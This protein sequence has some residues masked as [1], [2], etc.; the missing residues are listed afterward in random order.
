MARVT[1]TIDS[2][3]LV[4][5]ICTA[6]NSK[7][8]PAEEFGYRPICEYPFTRSGIPSATVQSP[9]GQCFVA[10]KRVR[11]ASLAIFL[12]AGHTHSFVV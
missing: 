7:N 12:D 1:K 6:H 2:A 8:S 10:S 9:L 3:I 5:Q 11:P 4:F